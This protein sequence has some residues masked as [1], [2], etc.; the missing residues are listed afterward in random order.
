MNCFRLYL[1]TVIA[2]Q[3]LSHADVINLSADQH[4]IL[5]DSS[6]FHEVHVVTNLPPTVV[7]LCGRL[8]EPGEKWETTDTITDASLPNRRLIW[9]VTDGEHY[10]VHYERGGRGHSFHVLFATLAKG[11]DKPTNVWRGVGEQLKDYPAFL[12]ALKN[13]KLDD[14]LDSSY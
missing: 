6:R 14:R 2:A 3:T 5:Q 4:K 13:N 8:A 1:L 12:D 7:A 10:I 9:A 11:D